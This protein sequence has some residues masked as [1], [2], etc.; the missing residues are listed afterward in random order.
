QLRTLMKERERL[1]TELQE[2]IQDATASAS[3][4]DQDQRLREAELE[5]I[6]L[7]AELD[8]TKEQLDQT[9]RELASLRAGAGRSEKMQEE[10]E[11]AAIE[12]L[13]VRDSLTGTRSQ[14]SRAQQELE[15]AHTELRA[16]RNEEQRAA[17]LEDGLRASKAELESI[18]ASHKA[19][20][21]E[22]EAD[23]E[24]KVRGTREEFQR[25]LDGIEASYREQL[26]QREADLAGRI[27]D[28][29]TA[30]RVA[31]DELASA[32]DELASAHDEVSAARAEAASRE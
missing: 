30:A 5:A 31:G 17:M 21:V 7:N 18:R 1:A 15:D 29:E 16:L 28:A 27:T 12:V 8:V 13:Q 24:E 6:G 4:D 11:A 19:D 26:G 23:L 3:G 20:L 14:L 32:R 2:T 9:R 25:Q 10:L 22:R